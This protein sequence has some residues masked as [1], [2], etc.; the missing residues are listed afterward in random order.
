M[1]SERTA[2]QS[3]L[4]QTKA[5]QPGYFWRLPLKPFR[6][7]KCYLSTD[8]RTAR[9]RKAKSGT[10]LYT[11]VLGTR[12]V[13]SPHWNKELRL[14]Y[15][16][17]AFSRTARVTD[18][19]TA[20]IS[21]TPVSRKFVPQKLPTYGISLSITDVERLFPSPMGQMRLCCW[22]NQA[23]TWYADNGHGIDQ[24]TIAGFSCGLKVHWT[25]KTNWSVHYCFMKCVHSL[26]TDRSSCKSAL[27]LNC[28]PSKE[29]VRN[30]YLPIYCYILL[31]KFAYTNKCLHTCVFP[32]PLN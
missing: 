24:F 5:F 20:K 28:M 26:H 14:S 30:S 7:L 12:L 22:G 18:S 4:I 21:E 8:T 29:W 31:G 23:L 25:I 11:N 2:F 19:P 1:Q 10:F 6:K 3:G 16:R 27:I 32:W 17:S 13:F 9:Q 15:I